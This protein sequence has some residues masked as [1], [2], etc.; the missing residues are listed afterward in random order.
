M[1]VYVYVYIYIYLI[2]I[3]STQGGTVTTVSYCSYEKRKYKKIKAYRKSIQK[4][5]TVNRCLLILDLRKETAT[6]RKETVEIDML[7]TS[8]NGD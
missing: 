1:Y 4:E 5:P 6:A 3:H 8:R 7:V 2:G